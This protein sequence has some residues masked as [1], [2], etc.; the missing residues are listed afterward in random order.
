MIRPR[1]AAVLPALAFVVLMMMMMGLSA[2]EGAPAR[3]D[4]LAIVPVATVPD[5]DILALDGAVAV[6][7]FGVGNRTYAVV[8]AA[9]DDGIQIVDITDPA[10]PVG[11]GSIM[12]DAGTILDGAYDVAIFGVGSRTYAVVAAVVEDGI[13]VIDVTDPAAP[14]GAGS[15][16]DDA[17]TALDGASAVDVFGVGSR[18]YAVVASYREGIQ[19]IN[20]TDPANP[21]ATAAIFDDDHTILLDNT[22]GVD[23]FGVGGST[24]AVAT[25]RND[26]GLEV[27]NVTDPASPVPV[28][29]IRDGG[30]G[31]TLL[32]GARGVDAFVVGGRT[33]AAV[34]ALDDN[35]IQVVEIADPSKPAAVSGVADGPALLLE[36]AVSVTTLNVGGAVYVLA[37]SMFENGV[38]V[39]DVTDPASPVPIHVQ[40]GD[41]PAP[42]GTARDLAVFERDGSV[43]A[44]VATGFFENSLRIL[45]VVPDGSLD[46]HGAVPPPAPVSAA[47]RPPAGSI[48]VTFDA[49]LGP[50]VHVDRLHVREAGRGDTGVVALSGRPTVEGA[51][52]TVALDAGQ[53]GSIGVMASPRLDVGGGAVQDMY[54]NPVPAAAGLPLDVPDTVPP[55]LDSATYHNSTGLLSVSF[56][57]PLD[58][59][60]T[61]YP[62][63]AI[64]GPSGNLTLAD[65]A[66][67][68]TPDG[69]T[70]AAT[71]DQTQR[72]MVGPD[73]TLKVSGGA[74][75][76]ESG[77]RIEPATVPITLTA[78]LPPSVDA[79]PDRTVTEGDGVALNGTATDPDPGDD[80]TYLWTHDSALAINLPNATAPSTA[81]TA[82]EVDADTVVIFTLTADDGRG[83]SSTDTVSV[84]ILAGSPPDPPQHLRF[85]ATTDTTVTLIWDDPDDATITGYKVLSRAALT[86]PNLAVLVSD[87]GS[88]ETTHTVTGLNPDTI[89]VFR[90]VA[91]GEHGESAWSNFVRLPT[92]PANPSLT[93]DAGPDRAVAEGS[94][95]TLS[96]TA[97][98]TGKQPTYLWT[99]D[100]PDLG[101]ALAGSDTLSPSF[102]TPDVDADTAVTFTLSVTDQRNATAADRVTITI[103][104]VPADDPPAAPQNLRFGATTNTT[105]TLIWDDPDDATITGYKVLSRAALTEPNLAVLVSDTGSA[106]TTHTVTGLNPDTI[107]VFR[108]VALGEHGESAW[109]N[110]VRPSTLP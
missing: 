54:G 82:P 89:Y 64:I 63:L 103:S 94:S 98:Y 104:D 107:Y 110:F 50:A 23:T 15:I 11:A 80:L 29:R 91:L 77:N 36:G 47:Y 42:G 25:S 33:Y 60:A 57:E 96:G 31:T 45:E 8:A 68:A 6:D 14:V 17:G 97:V 48:T 41:D 66:D 1:T 22:R 39:V 93:A 44:V 49:A 62:G 75:A 106:E 101:I 5:D 18:T 2:S 84:T 40:D 105:I 34:A 16:M 70:I 69:E 19:I 51:V 7:V 108:V 55:V 72:G 99:H 78:N 71:L 67:R 65:A 76:D 79:G 90:V 27:V 73:S 100:R 20:V 21:A 13:Q 4:P 37:V 109:S 24:Y 74:V 46:V 87:T 43:Y 10:A 81:F 102:T 92:A 28:A 30:S 95:V 83:A 53:A 26:D 85:G 32:E 86:E 9:R 88:A 38:Q 35:G 58:H 56:S 12:D 59:A 3:D 52:L 61:D